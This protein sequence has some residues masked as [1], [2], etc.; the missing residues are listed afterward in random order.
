MSETIPATLSQTV[1]IA[2]QPILDYIDAAVAALPPA[3]DGQDGDP[4]APGASAYDIWLEAGNTGTEADFLAS[5]KGADGQDGEDGQDGQDGTSSG[6]GSSVGYT[7]KSILDPEYGIN[8]D[9][10]DSAAKFKAAL[11]GLPRGT[12]LHIPADISLNIGSD[13]SLNT[14]ALSQSILNFGR[15]SSL[16]KTNP[17]QQ[18]VLSLKQ[19]HQFEI[20]GYPLFDLGT[21]TGSAA[22]IKVEDSRG[23]AIR[24]AKFK[25]ARRAIEFF[26]TEAGG[27]IADWTLDDVDLG[28]VTDYGLV[29]SPSNCPKTVENGTIYRGQTDSVLTGYADFTGG[30]SKSPVPSPTAYYGRF[31][32][33]VYDSVKVLQSYDTSLMV[34]GGSDIHV[35]HAHLHSDM[36]GIYLAN[37]I[38]A[39]VEDS[40]ITSKTDFGIASLCRPTAGWNP[41]MHLQAI[42]NYIHDCGKSGI[43]IEGNR[44]SEILSNKIRRCGTRSVSNPDE[45]SGISVRPYPASTTWPGVDRFP[46]FT[47]V[48]DNDVDNK[49]AGAT[50]GVRIAGLSSHPLEGMLVKNND[51]VGSVSNYA[52]TTYLAPS[53]TVLAN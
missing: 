26:S 16:L 23:W 39:L 15:G 27:G 50:Y 28:I 4:G 37:L 48:M 41:D 10:P 25:G 47:T 46:D 8:P 11:N 34:T 51:S 9:A 13:M 1:D 7:Q 31:D 53:S 43:N 30:V 38:G 35:K 29:A 42:S 22:G 19:A 40:E 21:S 52:F 32:G 14:G 5:L 36:V 3:Q 20:K 17:S 44:Y 33:L 18:R 24:K 2:A 6:G 49:D 45:K 12:E